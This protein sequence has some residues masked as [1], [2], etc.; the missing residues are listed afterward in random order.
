MR[1]S[2]RTIKEVVRTGVLITLSALLLASCSSTPSTPVGKTLSPQRATSRPYTIRGVK[3]RPQR[4]Y[5]YRQEGVA[6]YYGV[7]D[8]FHGKKTATGEKFNTHSLTAAHK[9]VPLP[10]MLL[11]TNLDN[12]RSLKVKANDRG[13]FVRGRIIDVSEKAAQ[14]LGFYR[15]GTARVRVESLVRDS[16]ALNQQPSRR[17]QIHLAKG[18]SVRKG[19]FRNV[20]KFVP[21]LRR[22]IVQPPIR[23][24]YRQGERLILASASTPVPRRRPNRIMSKA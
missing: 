5:E 8:G 9:T 16:L 4:H 23:R 22:R 19:Y 20:K 24:R 21:K 7:R 3:Y 10:C 18:P 14:L 15:K 6:S 12:G 17:P 13:P 11:V 1:H 2:I